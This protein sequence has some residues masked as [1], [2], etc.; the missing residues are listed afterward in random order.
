MRYLAAMGV[1]CQ[2][3]S[4]QNFVP[5][6]NTKVAQHWLEPAPQKFVSYLLPRKTLIALQKTHNCQ[7]S[8]IVS[9]MQHNEPR[10]L[11]RT[12]RIVSR[13]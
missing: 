5:L 4:L 7:I 12:H 1:E 11:N 2:V 9:H 13:L 10:M 3:Q 6:L 8:T